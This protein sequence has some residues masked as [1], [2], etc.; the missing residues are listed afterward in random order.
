M[1]LLQ[2]FDINIFILKKVYLISGWKPEK[3]NSEINT[4]LVVEF[5][6]N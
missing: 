6:F 4:N 1:Y 2:L 5:K 3:K